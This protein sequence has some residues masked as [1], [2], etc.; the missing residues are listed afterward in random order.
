MSSWFRERSTQNLKWLGAKPLQYCVTEKDVKCVGITHD[1]DNNDYRLT[2]NSELPKHLILSLANILQAIFTLYPI[3]T[4]G[5]TRE[6]WYS[7]HVHSI[8]VIWVWRLVGDIAF[9]PYG[10]E[11]CCIPSHCTPF[12]HSTN[13]ET[14]NQRHREFVALTDSL[15]F[16]QINWPRKDRSKTCH[17]SLNWY[18]C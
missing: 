8:S 12:H 9:L 4:R 13:Q 10:Q 11:W 7:H 16:V 18:V 6:I 2:S 5:L 3:R 14:M 17:C 1:F 15:L